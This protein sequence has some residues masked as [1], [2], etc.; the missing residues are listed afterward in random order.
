[1]ALQLPFS[2]VFCSFLFFAFSA[3]PAG[4]SLQNAGKPKPGAAQDLQKTFSA[5]AVEDDPA[6]I[7][8]INKS[9]TRGER[10]LARNQGPQGSWQSEER[11]AR[12]G[13]S[14]LALYAL[15]SSSELLTP[16]Q[17]KE[18]TTKKAGEKPLK[19]TKPADAAKAKNAD[20]FDPEAHSILISGAI[21]KGF[22]FV[23]KE[24]FK[25]TYAL[26]LL[27]LAIDAYAAPRWERTSM[28]R[29]AAD[30]KIRYKYPRRLT[31]AD[32]LW[33]QQTV[34]ELCNHRF[35]GLWSYRKNAG[36]GD[37]SNTQFAVLGLR[38]AANCGVAIDPKIWYESIEY[39]LKFQDDAGPPASYPMLRS[40][41]GI[42][43]TIEVISVDAQQ[44]SWGYSFEKGGTP[45]NGKD[46]PVQKKK[47][48]PIIGWSFGATGTH[49]SIGIAS[50]QIARD[51]VNRCLR[52]KL[53]ADIRDKLQKDNSR[54][55]K[56]IRDGLGWLAG[57][58]NLEE[59]PG[60]GFPFYYLYSVER[61]GALLGERFLAG[62]DWYREGAEIL[63]RRQL[64]DGAW[65]SD[66][67]E[68][69]A[70]GSPDVTTTSFAL[71]FLRRATA[72]AVITPD[73]GEG[74]SKQNTTNR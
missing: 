41:I 64:P 66:M 48:K 67:G 73:F 4:A 44:R 18:L 37:I 12:I 53:D 40:K 57:N 49:T 47:D 39:F 45:M 17:L 72:P 30:A 34:D 29:M 52:A 59:D 1:M 11:S 63:L 42:D 2:S 15:T 6:L 16:E 14:E 54:I 68:V 61:V 8:R 55:D 27:L 43:K 20:A 26:S 28:A 58:W 69:N 33:I 13:Y 62:H 35:K 22:Q 51:E 32:R 38:A 65:P 7:E 24:P 9:I 56:A 70:F 5:P 19:T 74:K 3:A 36:T 60:G 46:G 21:E 71:L 23:K 31:S 50:L 25:E 10:W